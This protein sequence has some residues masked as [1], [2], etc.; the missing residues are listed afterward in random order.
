MV[1]QE[2]GGGK[3]LVQSRDKHRKGDT[4]CVK[5]EGIQEK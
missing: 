1:T 5:K 4:K 3:F 2:F